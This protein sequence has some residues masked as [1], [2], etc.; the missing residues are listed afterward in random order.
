[1]KRI[2]SIALCM[3]LILAAVP[4]SV[5]AGDAGSPRIAVASAS[6]K[7]EGGDVAL[8][9]SA[10]DAAE[11]WSARFNVKVPDAFEIVSFEAS[12]LPGFCAVGPLTAED[13]VAFDWVGDVAEDA[14]AV[15]NELED[16]AICSP[17]GSA[18][19]ELAVITVRVP[20]GTAADD[21][22][23]EVVLSTE[24]DDILDASGNAFAISS[25]NGTLTVFDATY[26]EP[27]WAWDKDAH[28][29][30]VTFPCDQGE[31]FN[32]TLNA[33]VTS[34]TT[35]NPTCEGEGLTTYTAKVT[36]GGVE[37][38]DTDTAPISPTG[39]KWGEPSWDWKEDLSGAKAT[40][41]CVNDESH[42]EN[43]DAT[44]SSA[45]T[46]PAGCET[47]GVR[48]YT[49]KVTFDNKEYTD[50]KDEPVASIGHAY[51]EG[52]WKWAE[53]FSKA[54]F[55][56]T[57]KNDA[58][59]TIEVKADIV[60]NVKTEAKCE[61]AGEKV[62]TA[63]AVYEGVEYTDEKSETIPA[64][65]HAY[66]EPEWAW[67][68]DLSEA[69]AT[70]TCKNDASHT[71]TVDATITSAVTTEATT[72]A[73]GVK[74]F[75]AKAT[76]DG[77]EYTD[78]KTQSIPKL[79]DSGDVDNPPA[80]SGAKVSLASS[81]ETFQNAK[82]AISEIRLSGASDVTE[83]TVALT[84]PAG[85][86]LDEAQ[87]AAGLEGEVT[88]GEVKKNAD[89]SSVVEIKWANAKALSEDV[90][91]T[92][93]VDLPDGNKLNDELSLGLDL[94]EAKKVD[95]GA[96]EIEAES[97][98]VKFGYVIFDI[99]DDGKTN[100]KDVTEFMKFLVGVK[101]EKKLFTERGDINYDGFLNARDC[102]SA[103]KYLVGAS[104]KLYY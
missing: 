99:N 37:Y 58:T 57:C 61:V 49:A 36:F 54:A 92:V 70:F 73:E 40:F 50:T 103:M 55:V 8:K 88:I 47:A 87:L 6:V 18:D 69:K 19:V 53:D 34:E 72:E 65:G 42:V 91:I 26:G 3:M 24:E 76:F 102:T 28:S 64:T 38:S 22:T 63:T 100:A 30:S 48:T 7:S 71:Q 5:I 67:E 32:S 41:T 93:T 89:G 16:V 33:T 94:V 31:E 96:V 52:A 51:D 46:T 29:A 97:G 62:Y 21:Y 2:V 85:V 104:S 9:I 15:A 82:K 60:S 101:S 27:V 74:T 56:F 66:G 25:E 83:F 13:G 78:A 20:A 79:D 14:Q 75:T 95:G 86:S 12:D 4:Y 84:L 1:M 23:V 77:K 35:T 59:H 90:V 39:H 98:S 10:L 17:L 80:P 45:V 81:A 11:L 68:V 44:I 43:V